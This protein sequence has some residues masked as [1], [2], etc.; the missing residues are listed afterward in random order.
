[1]SY[2]GEAS[3]TSCPGPRRVTGGAG[4]WQG[5]ARGSEGEAASV[6]PPWEVVGGVSA[7]VDGREGIGSR[8]EQYRPTGT[9]RRWV[10]EGR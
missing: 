10:L 1:M 8:A 5:A 7:R 3:L 6:S 4:G 2:L 9:L